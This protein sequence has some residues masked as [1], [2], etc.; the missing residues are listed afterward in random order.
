[1]RFGSTANE[2]RISVMTLA[3]VGNVRNPG[4][5]EVAAGVG[6]VPEPVPTAVECP[7]RIGV[8]EATLR[9]RTSEMEV[10]VVVLTR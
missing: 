8:E 6:C 5:I 1:M 9:R 2:S 10:G 4:A 7:V 3:E